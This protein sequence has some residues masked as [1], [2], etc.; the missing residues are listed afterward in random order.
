MLWS[1]M[2]C[3][4][5]FVIFSFYTFLFW[6]YKCYVL[7]SPAL[8]IYLIYLIL[9][10]EFYSIY[11]ILIINFYL[12]IFIF[13]HLLQLYFPYILILLSF[14]HYGLLLAYTFIVWLSIWTWA[15]LCDFLACQWTQSLKN[16]WMITVI[17]YWLLNVFF[18]TT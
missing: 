17:L 8:F 2:L 3:Y 15:L 1:I 7:Q 4:V 9:T 6:V 18:L 16:N 14:S 11:N 13:R 12:I 10:N 5:L